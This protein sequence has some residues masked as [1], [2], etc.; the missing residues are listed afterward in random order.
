MK[1]VNVRKSYGIYIKN[2]YSY[3]QAHARFIETALYKN[4]EETC[5]ITI[6][7]RTEFKTKRRAN[8]E[9]AQSYPG[10]L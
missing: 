7:R 8:S 2:L 1:N 3:L 6:G 9:A 10:I 5:P 4:K